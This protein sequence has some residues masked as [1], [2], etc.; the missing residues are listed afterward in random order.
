MLLRGLVAP[1]RLRH[2]GGCAFARR[3]SHVPPARLLRLPLAARAPPPA[4]RRLLAPRSAVCRAA[5]LCT[6]PAATTAVVNA[7]KAPPPAKWSPRWMWN[8]A[9]EIALHYWHGSKLLAADTRIASKLL[10]RLVTGHHLS[11]REHNLL[12]RVLADLGRVIPLS[13]FVLVPFMEFAR[14]RVGNGAV[15]LDAAAPCA[16]LVAHRAQAAPAHAGA[17]PKHPEKPSAW[18]QSPA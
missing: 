8:S 10:V 18:P 9:V 1:S 14:P 6:K 11:R 5:L 16:R 17:R 12:V 15:L 4:R 3:L 7:A 2:P 13:F